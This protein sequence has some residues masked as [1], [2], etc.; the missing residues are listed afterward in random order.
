[1]NNR[2]PQFVYIGA[3]R[4]GST[5]LYCNLRQHPGLWVPPTK[6]INYFHPRFATYR[7]QSFTRYRFGQDMI[8]HPDPE[9][10]F[11]YRQFFGRRT[12]D[13]QWY[14]ALFPV[15]RIGGEIAESYCTLDSHTVR[16]IRL[17]YPDLRVII[18][19][20]NPME[21]A[22]SQAKLALAV[23]RGRSTTEV[24]VRDFIRHLAYRNSLDRSD[25][26]H[27][28]DIW[29]DLFADRF[30]IL[31]Y[32][33]L[34]EDPDDYMARICRF[35]GAE[36]PAEHFGSSLRSVVNRSSEAS[37]PPEVVSFAARLYQPMAAA[38]A[39]RLGGPTTAWL[40]DIEGIIVAGTPGTARLG[41]LPPEPTG[42]PVRLRTGNRWW[43]KVVANGMHAAVAVAALIECWRGF[44]RKVTRTAARH[45]KL[46]A[47]GARGCGD[48]EE[49]R[50]RRKG[51]NRRIG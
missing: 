26:L 46:Q 32:E 41:A 31:F 13:D 24:P 47:Q 25:Y 5:W 39:C 10:R 34:R 1:M 3:P 18:T 45:A 51:S 8:R 48:T 22:L 28:L 4:T 43:I 36:F 30:M 33:L 17:L 6:S 21:R 42:L 14:A 19:L 35:V 20:R 7:L 38:V 44:W 49:H 9:T 11:W 37:L 2:G 29:G 40:H 23:R 27:M 12:V 16:R 50:R 15:D